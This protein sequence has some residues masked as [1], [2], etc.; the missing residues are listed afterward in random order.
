M[1]EFPT[2]LFHLAMIIPNMIYEGK[3][4]VLSS[5]FRGFPAYKSYLGTKN[6]ISFNKIFRFNQTDQIIEDLKK[7]AMDYYQNPASKGYSRF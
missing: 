7:Y 2:D 6:D 1:V 4:R 5:S 3:K